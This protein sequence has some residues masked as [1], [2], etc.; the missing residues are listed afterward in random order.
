MQIQSSRLDGTW[1]PG[2]EIACSELSGSTKKPERHTRPLCSGLP[3][4]RSTPCF[5][6]VPP[7]PLSSVLPTR[8]PWRPEGA[9]SVPGNSAEQDEEGPGPERTERKP[10]VVPSHSVEGA[11]GSCTPPPNPEH[12]TMG[13]EFQVQLEGSLRRCSA[14]GLQHQ[15]LSEFPASQPDLQIP[16][17][18]VP[19]IS[20]PNKTH[21]QA[22]FGPQAVSEQVPS[23]TV[24]QI[25]HSVSSPFCLSLSLCELREQ[26]LWPRVLR[27]D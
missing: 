7:C 12:R 22:R 2:Q 24:L 6:A 4:L 8:N 27:L 13:A 11:G 9:A 26:R 25:L 21:L 1:I 18:V 15:L 14:S 3:F 20:R 17:L 10:A 5:S 19:T 23:P 16:N